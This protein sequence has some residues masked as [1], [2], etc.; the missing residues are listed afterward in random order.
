MKNEKVFVGLSGGVDSSVSAALLK[1][2]GY[3]VTGVYMKNWSGDNY[4]IQSDCPWER[5]QEDAMSVAES[6]GIDF[7]SYNFERDYR[8][9]V[10]EYFFNEYK[11]GRTPNPDVMCNKEIKFQLF[12]NKALSE[13]ANYIATGHYVQKINL[14]SYSNFT[15]VKYKPNSDLLLKGVDNNKDQSYFLNAINQDQLNKS[16]FPVGGFQK[17]KVRELAKKFNLPNADKP[18]SQGIC[19]IGEINVKDFLK[20]RLG[21]KQGEIIDIDSQKRVGE[22]NGAYFYTI[23]QRE[24]LHIGGAPKP[25]F[26]VATDIEKNIVYVAMGKNTKHLYSSEV[27]FTD[28]NFVSPLESNTNI[29]TELNKSEFLSASIR[30]RH[31]S[32]KGKIIQKDDNIFC[33][34]FEEKQR[35]VTPGQSIVIYDGEICVCGGTIVSSKL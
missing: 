16:I 34:S 13:G 7:I 9:K 33:F 10:V 8:D 35:A 18:D 27:Y 26:V 14:N 11:A 22:H 12:L 19:F 17:S 32:E 5:D 23:G 1:E 20:S 30:Y 15:K 3:N 4:G 2:Q 31:K 29:T 24:G 25:Y 6:L 21:E 28:L